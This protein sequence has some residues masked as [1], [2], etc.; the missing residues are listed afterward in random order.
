MR[1]AVAGSTGLVGSQVVAVA[2]AAGHSVVGL[3]REDGVDLTSP[4]G[5]DERLAGVEA[6]VDV[7]QSPTIDI[8]AVKFFETVAANLG[9]AATSAGVSRTVLLSIIGV[10]RVP[11]YDYYVAKVAQER[12]HRVHSPGL[13]V[14]RAAQF[15]DFPGM[16]IR[17]GR[18]GDTTTVDDLLSQPVAVG[19]IARV[20]VELATGERDDD[21]IELAGPRQ[22][23]IVDLARRLVA[24]SGEHLTVIA[25]DVPEP[26]RNGALL[27]GSGAIIAGPTFDEWLSRQPA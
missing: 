24:H 5:L 16:A 18:D 19:E 25:R 7:T 2:K 10:D 17:W 9:D 3:A 4:V 14:L 21:V 12:T 6:L 27:P 13:H 1:I 22:E 23:R 26:M 20:L 8:E 11:Q 15:L